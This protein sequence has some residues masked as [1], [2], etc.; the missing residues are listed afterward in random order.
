MKRFLPE[1]NL[2]AS[3][4]KNSFREKKWRSPDEKIPSGKKNGGL[5][6]EKFLRKKSRKSLPT[7][8]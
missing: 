4:R 1:K 6:T 8:N 3:R 5:P 2:E 7:K